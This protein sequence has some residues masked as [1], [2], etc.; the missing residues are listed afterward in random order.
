M[1]DLIGADKESRLIATL[2][3]PYFIEAHFTYAAP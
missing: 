3:E 1:S 2:D